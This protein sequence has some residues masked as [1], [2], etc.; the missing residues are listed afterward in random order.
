M[1][2]PV[3][4]KLSFPA[5]VL[6]AV[7][8]GGSRAQG[9]PHDAGSPPQPGAP[10]AKSASPA[11]TSTTPPSPAGHERASANPADPNV[12]AVAS[13]INIFS[14]IVDPYDYETR[15]RRDPFGQPVP[16][17]PLVQGAAHGPLLPLQKFDLGQLRVMAILWD[18]SRPQAMLKDPSGNIYIV[19][20]NSKIGPNNGYVASIREGEIVVVETKEQDGRLV[21]TPLVLKIAK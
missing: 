10:P 4:N 21:S 2:V 19:T 5:L 14:G 15:G 13:P 12:Q 11:G 8:T 6:I 17:K 18:V 9:Q 1:A 16:D 20:P 7:M 3:V